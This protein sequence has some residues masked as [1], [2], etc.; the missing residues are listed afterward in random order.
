MLLIRYYQSDQ[1]FS[2]P[3]A[4]MYVCI[5]VYMY[6]CMYVNLHGKAKCVPSSKHRKINVDRSSST[7][8]ETL[9]IIEVVWLLLFQQ[10][11]G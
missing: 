8:W 9:S 11:L 10:P 5:Y 2:M 6:V 1:S 7:C 4:C 3:Y